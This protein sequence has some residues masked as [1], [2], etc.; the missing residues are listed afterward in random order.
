MMDYARS[1]RRFDSCGE[2][3]RPYSQSVSELYLTHQRASKR[4]GVGTGASTQLGRNGLS[5]NGYECVGGMG[6]RVEGRLEK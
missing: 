1:D 6:G 5:H 4:T 2:P 3:A